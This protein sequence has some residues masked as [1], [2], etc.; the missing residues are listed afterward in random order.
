[1]KRWRA[2]D[3]L[4][5]RRRKSERVIR[6]WDRELERFRTSSR[7]LFLRWT[8]SLHRATA[9]PTAPS[10]SIASPEESTSE[11]PCPVGDSIGIAPTDGP[12]A[13]RA[14]S[15]SIASL[16]HSRPPLV[17]E[18][19][20]ISCGRTEHTGRRPSLLHPREPTFPPQPPAC[21]P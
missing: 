9:C 12:A 20:F 13:P 5:G 10:S 6:L 18:K 4:S 1:M 7:F 2:S 3:S 17:S 21:L 11:L 15:S 14:L 8:H 19:T 16:D